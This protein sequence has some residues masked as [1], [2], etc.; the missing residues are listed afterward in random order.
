MRAEG[1]ALMVGTGVGLG[2][3]EG[4]VWLC[5]NETDSIANKHHIGL[6]FKKTCMLLRRTIQVSGKARNAGH[7]SDS[8]DLAIGASNA[9]W[10]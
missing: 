5:D 9:V 2:G 7:R 10:P 3:A 6:I 4:V 8:R 1:A